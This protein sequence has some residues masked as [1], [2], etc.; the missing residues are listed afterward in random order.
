MFEAQLISQAPCENRLWLPSPRL[1]WY[2]T[3]TG[4]IILHVLLPLTPHWFLWENFFFFFFN[5][6]STRSSFREGNGT[7]PILLPGKSHEQRSLEGCSPWGR[8]GSDMTE[9]LQFHFSLSCIE[10]EMATHSTVL[11][12]KIPG[13]PETGGLTSMETQKVR[14]DWSDLAAAAGLHCCSGLLYFQGAGITL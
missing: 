1:A 2:Q 8:W 14:H 5:F 12:W 7:L 4:F 13:I 9:R 6:G 3:Q 11:A 10:K